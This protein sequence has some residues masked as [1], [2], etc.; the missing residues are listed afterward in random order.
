MKTIK[1][2]VN[3][4]EYRSTEII[5]LIKSKNNKVEK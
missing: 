3:K 5:N 1:E 4:L 2:N